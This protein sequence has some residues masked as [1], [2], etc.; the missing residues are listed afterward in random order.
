MRWYPDDFHHSF[1]RSESLA[2]NTNASPVPTPQILVTL[3]SWPP[4]IRS[5]QLRGRHV[6]GK[7]G[8]MA[9]PNVGPTAL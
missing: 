3:E 7:F 8:Q 9:E 4:L 6:K 5:E 1:P 2:T